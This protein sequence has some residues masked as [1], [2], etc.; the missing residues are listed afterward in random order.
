MNVGDRIRIRREQLGMKQEE[1]GRKIGYKSRASINK[2]ESNQRKLPQDK[3]KIIA[4]ALMT[5]P[6]Y[7]MGWDDEPVPDP[8]PKGI[9]PLEKRAVPMIGDVACGEPMIANQ[10]FQS[11][12]EI[13]ANINCDCCLRARGDSMKNIRIYD[14]DIVFIKRQPMVENGD[15][16]AIIINDEVTLKRFYY[17]QENNLIILKPENS[18]YKDLIYSGSDLEQIKVFGKAVA[19]QSDI[20]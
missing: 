4:D 14:G 11:Y 20:K 6:G 13:G 3:I 12:V 2:I 8:L 10:E 17:Y 1:L 9:K 19:F 5:T 15:V 16:A 18:E 7:I